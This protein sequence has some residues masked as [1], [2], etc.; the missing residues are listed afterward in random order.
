MAK[1]GADVEKFV[2]K[3]RADFKRG[4][5]SQQNV[6]ADASK[7]IA[8]AFEAERRKHEEI[9]KRLA[10]ADISKA[11]SQLRALG[12]RL[13][14][15]NKKNTE[16]VKTR[17][18]IERTVEARKSAINKLRAV[19]VERAGKRKAKAAEY[20][21]ALPDIVELDVR[22]LGD[23]ESLFG[24]LRDLSKG[25]MVKEADLTKVCQAYEP[26]RICE[27]I[28]ADDASTIA[29][30]S[31]VSKDVAARLVAKCREKGNAKV[32]EL[33]ALPLGDVPVFR[34]I[35][36]PGRSKALAELSTG[37]KGTLIIALAL[38]E[39]TGPLVVDHPEEPLDT[40]S[41]YG[42]VVSKLR[43]GKESRQFIFTT[44]NANIAVGADAD[45]SHVLGATADRGSIE[46]SGGVDHEE[47]NRLLLLHLEGGADAL[48]RRVRKY[49]P[50]TR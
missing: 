18:R 12:T 1:I 17:A 22:P 24:A 4:I 45:L 23:R 49:R 35:V 25:A 30:D 19:R 44:H 27:L 32:Y 26:S 34:Y 9:L 43:Q 50:S 48:A 46:S 29:T 38:V 10:Q 13:E 7:R 20:Q 41:I 40:K 47:T 42:Q 36:S 8:P 37:Q 11:T 31:G 21:S 16:R 5:A 14:A 28:L 39:G 6:I 3:A 2:K 33:D 15:L